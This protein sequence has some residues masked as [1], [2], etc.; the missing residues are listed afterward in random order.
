MV[1]FLQTVGVEL[2]KGN[3]I[4]AICQFSGFSIYIII[5]LRIRMHRDM[6][7]KRP[8]YHE[9]RHREM[10]TVCH[11]VGHCG[12]CCRLVLHGCDCH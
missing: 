5:L 7:N 1:C 6:A 8:I 3:V 10:I 9:V 11:H 12:I 4:G 2:F